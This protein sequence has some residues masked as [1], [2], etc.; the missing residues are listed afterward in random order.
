MTKHGD[1][2]KYKSLKTAKFQA[3]RNFLRGR[4]G[5]LTWSEK[6]CVFCGKKSSRSAILMNGLRC[7]APCDKEQWPEKITKSEAKKQYDLKDHHLLPAKDFAPALA[8]LLAKHP[9]GL[10]KLRYGTYISSNVATTMF[11]RKDVEALAKFAHGDLKEH[12]DKKQA[13]RNERKRKDEERKARGEAEAAEMTAKAIELRQQFA[14][15]H[16]DPLTWFTAPAP[17]ISQEAIADAEEMSMLASEVPFILEL[18]GIDMDDDPFMGMYEP[19]S[20]ASLC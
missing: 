20:V 15:H 11:L 10:P 2:T 5:L 16:Q 17:E 12:L 19:V 3:R 4:G 18:A 6:N 14:A 9:G 8:K 1:I 13:A 7:C